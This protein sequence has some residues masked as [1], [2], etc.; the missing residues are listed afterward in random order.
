MDQRNEW[1]GILDGVRLYDDEI[2]EILMRGMTIKEFVLQYA[3]QDKEDEI[4]E[5]FRKLRVVA[6]YSKKENG[7]IIQDKSFIKV[8]NLLECAEQDMK[9][10]DNINSYIN[11]GTLE[12]GKIKEIQ[13]VIFQG[14]SDFMVYILARLKV[15]LSKGYDEKIFNKSKKEYASKVYKYSRIMELIDNNIRKTQQKQL[16]LKSS[17]NER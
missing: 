7:D 1:V 16:P 11:Y 10:Y 5:K 8:L 12:K 3:Q 6:E 13:D 14:N 4:R 2:T 17:G 15:N 9:K